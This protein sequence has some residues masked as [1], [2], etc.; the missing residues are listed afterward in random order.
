[1]VKYS[2]DTYA[3]AVGTTTLLVDTCAVIP[4]PLAPL[5]HCRIPPLQSY[6]TTTAVMLYHHRCHVIPRLQSYYTTAAVILYCHRCHIVPPQSYC[7]T[8]PFMLYHCR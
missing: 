8:A 6:C 7:T 4:P 2:P 3:T 1:M 5:L